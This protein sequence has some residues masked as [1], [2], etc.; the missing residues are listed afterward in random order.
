M[1]LQHKKD[2]PVKTKG[3]MDITPDEAQ[4]ITIGIYK[5]ASSSCIV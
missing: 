1:I 4:K 2:T 3:A 5:F